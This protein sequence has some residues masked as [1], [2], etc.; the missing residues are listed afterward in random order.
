MIKHTPGFLVTL[1]ALMLAPAISNA[2]PETEPHGSAA[3]LVGYAIHDYGGF[4]VG[5]RGGYTL[6]E[7]IYI[8]GTFIYNFGTSVDQIGAEAKFN[9]YYLGV[10]GGYD[11]QVHPVII[12]PYMGIGPGFFHSSGEG[13]S[14]LGC[15]NISGTNT[16]FALWFGG[17]VL[18]PINEQWFVGGDLKLP[19][20]DGEVMF[21][22]AAT[23]GLNF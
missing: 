8:G 12:R 11:F 3:A 22:M 10:E 19:V 1:G 17:T 2:M 14:A 7:N 13:C 9:S 21:T 4:S 6:R 23:G 16:V 15:V 20:L 18:Y 5:A